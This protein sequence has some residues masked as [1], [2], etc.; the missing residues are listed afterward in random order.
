MAVSKPVDSEL[1]KLH[2]Y[3]KINLHLSEYGKIPAIFTF[4]QVLELTVGKEEEE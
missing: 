4:I 3:G 1:C 2:Q